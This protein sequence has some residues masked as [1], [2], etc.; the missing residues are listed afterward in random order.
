MG[1]G[2][3]LAVPRLLERHGLKVDDIDLWELNEAFASQM[4]YCMDKLGI[5]HDKINVNGGAISIGHPYG[6]SGARMTGHLLLEGR[7]RRR[8]I[9]RRH[10]VHRRRHGRGRPVRDS[11]ADCMRAIVSCACLLLALAAARAAPTSDVSRAG[12]RRRPIPRP[13]WRRW[14]PASPRWSRNER[15]KLDPEAKPLALDPELAKIARERARAT[16]RRRIISPMP[17]P[18][19]TPRA[20]LLMA[21]D[22]NFQG[23]LGENLA[24]QHYTRQS[25]VDVDAFAQRFLDDW[26]KSPPHRENLAFTDYDRTGV[27]AAV[28]G[29]TVYV[30]QLFATDLGLPHAQ[31]RPRR[32]A[33]HQAR[34]PRGGGASARPIRSPPL[35]LRGAVAAQ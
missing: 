34:Q 26:L 10:H 24:A 16:W 28:N 35:R 14:K 4:L 12:R 6:M 9:R 30:A 18:T 11:A 29:D 33:R 3:V 15:L 31:K 19:A 23:L 32:P 1:I 27:G 7:R 2:P 13:R 22:A 5:P 20:T 17:R 25:G 8:Q 21:E